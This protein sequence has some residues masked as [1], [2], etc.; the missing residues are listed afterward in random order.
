MPLTPKQ[1]VKWFEQQGS[2]KKVARA[3]GETYRTARQAYTGAVLAGL[4]APLR[5]GAKTREQLKHPAKVVAPK[6]Q[7]QRRATRAKVLPLPSSGKINKYLFSC[8]QNNTKLNTQLLANI[9]ALLAHYD[10]DPR[11]ESAQLMV[12]RIFYMKQGL[13][14]NGDKSQLLSGKELGGG[15]EITF[16]KETV[17]YQ[18]D[19]RVQIAPGLVWCGE[20][21]T[22]P[23]AAR[24][25]TG[26]E[27]YTG[28]KSGIFPHMKVAMQSI[29]S[30]ADEGT[31]FNYTTGCLSQR[32]YIQRAAGLKADFHHCYGALLAE[33]DE[34]GNWWCRQIV[35]DTNGTIY[36]LDLRVKDGKVL[37]GNWIDSI[38][39]GDIH[40]QCLEPG[41]TGMVWGR[42]GVLEELKPRRQFIHDLLDFRSR[43]H[44]EMKDPL[45]LY[46]KHITGIESV[47]AEVRAAACWL[48]GAERSW[49]E[50]IVVNS[51]H[52]RHIGRWLKDQDA[53]FDPANFLFW[54]ALWGA[55]LHDVT[56]HPNE[57]VNY[58][59]L[60]CGLEYYTGGARF[61]AQDESYIVCHD[62]GGGVECGLHGDD[63]PNG[64]RGTP[65]AFARMGRKMVTAHSHQAGI[66]DG[67]Y[68][69]GTFSR[70]RPEYVVG[71]GSWSH[72]FCPIYENGKR[73]LVTIWNG[74]YR[75]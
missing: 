62:D 21:N 15:V 42:N 19:E 1:F 51:N 9:Q 64:A 11:V 74:K 44:H 66:T 20:T 43:S 65:L 56:H 2:I 45:K 73:C 32:N 60:A 39:W 68:V 69:V 27:S 10:A 4:M 5:V 16:P 25:L 29:P 28:R 41:I 26:F 46:T 23:T 57:P 67:V 36:D 55:V 54:N 75:A 17:I 71:P 53:R 38:V 48:K 35:G 31:K 63:G 8:V 50:T 59:K 22:L 12:S 52:D 34:A 49:C 14:A 37:K 61:L 7:G 70:L 30:M 13:G 47:A 18:S 3:T 24:P 33:V 72:T 40:V 58:L 6:P